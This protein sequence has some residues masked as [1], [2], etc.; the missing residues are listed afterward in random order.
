MAHHDLNP[1]VPSHVRILAHDWWRIPNLTYPTHER[2]PMTEKL[3]NEVIAELQELAERH[4]D[5]QAKCREWGS[6]EGELESL[7]A[8]RKTR[9]ILRRLKKEMKGH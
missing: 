6:E 7:K 2:D 3:L 4:A 5:D 1:N 8:E 9:A